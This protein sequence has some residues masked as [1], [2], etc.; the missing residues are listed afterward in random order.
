M[1]E[2]LN[3]LLRGLREDLREMTSTWPTSQ[4]IHTPDQIR[5]PED[6]VARRS[7]VAHYADGSTET[8]KV[9]EKD[10]EGGKSMR[11]HPSDEEGEFEPYSDFGLTPYGGGRWHPTNYLTPKP[12]ISFSL[13]KF[14][15]RR[16]KWE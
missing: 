7:Y 15:Q 11:V 9:L 5:S 4:V 6:I 1:T 16:R 14:F 3:E 10:L 8:F 12:V 2:E 13:P